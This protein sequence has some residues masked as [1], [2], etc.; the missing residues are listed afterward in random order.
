MFQNSIT[1]LDLDEATHSEQQC[2]DVF[3]S[4]PLQGYKKDGYAFA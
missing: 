4:V 3:K 2:F 1:A